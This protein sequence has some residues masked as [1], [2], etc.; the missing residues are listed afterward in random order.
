MIT[1][2]DNQFCNGPDTE[3]ATLADAKADR[4]AVVDL[5]DALTTI[6]EVCAYDMRSDWPGV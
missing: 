4:L 6:E 5:A 3:F 1:Y 2:Q